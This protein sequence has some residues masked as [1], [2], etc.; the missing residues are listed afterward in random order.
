M[1]SLAKTGPTDHCSELKRESYNVIMSKV[2]AD[3][4]G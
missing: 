1:N 4:S 2:N 3:K